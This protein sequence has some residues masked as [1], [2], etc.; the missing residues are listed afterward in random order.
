MDALQSK[1]V[2]TIYL[3]ARSQLLPTFLDGFVYLYVHVPFINFCQ[4]AYFALPFRP[5]YPL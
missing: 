4:S 5:R 1:K 3:L 2:A